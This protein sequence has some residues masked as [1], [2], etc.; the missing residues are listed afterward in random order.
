MLPANV[1]SSIDSLPFSNEGYEP[2]K[3]IL[4]LKYSKS[5]EVIIAHVQE[6]MG[7]P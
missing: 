2:A 3:S 7:L 1:R 5:S 4:K 6:I